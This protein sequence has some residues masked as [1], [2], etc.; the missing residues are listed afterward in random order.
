MDRRRHV[1]AAAKEFPDVS[2]MRGQK[3]ALTG[4]GFSL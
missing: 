3:A 1:N 2:C 4:L